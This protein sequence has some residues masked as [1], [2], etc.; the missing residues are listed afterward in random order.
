MP[1][2]RRIL[3]KLKILEVSGVDKPAQEGALVA[4]LKRQNSKQETE[5]MTD[6]EL[7]EIE[8]RDLTAQLA[9]QTQAGP[10]KAF[11]ELAN[12]IIKRDHCSKSAALVKARKES[13]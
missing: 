3:E 7:L 9:K 8:V 2:K 1:P 11:E 4:L 12:E 5:K 10:L 6:A 13:P